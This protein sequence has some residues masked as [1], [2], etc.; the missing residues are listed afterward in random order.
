[1][2]LPIISAP[3]LRSP[4]AA[5]VAVIGADFGPNWT[6]EIIGTLPT[7]AYPSIAYETRV[8]V[9]GGVWPYTYELFNTIPSGMS[10]SSSTGIIT[11]TAPS[12]TSNHTIDIRITDQ[13]GVQDT[14]NYTI[15]VDATNFFF[16]DAS[17]TDDTGT[18]AIGDPWKTLGKANTT[19][20][21][22][23]SILIR[24]GTYSITSAT[25]FSNSTPTIWQAYP[26]DTQ[27]VISVSADEGVRLFYDNLSGNF[28][29]F[30]G[31]EFT[32][33]DDKTFD[34][35][36]GTNLMFYKNFMHDIVEDG[37]NNNP[38]FVSFV[39]IGASFHENFRFMNNVCTSITGTGSESKAA[40]IAFNVHNSLWESN[41][42]TDI[43]AYGLLDKD[44]TFHN[45]YRDN[46]ISNC[47]RTMS[48]KAQ[49]GADGCNIHHNLFID[50]TRNSYG[51]SGTPMTEIYWHHNMMRDTNFEF[52]NNMN[53]ESTISMRCQYNVM[54]ITGSFADSI[55][56]LYRTNATVHDKILDGTVFEA[57]NNII[58]LVDSDHCAGEDEGGAPY[59]TQA[60]WVSGGQDTNSSFETVTLTGIDDTLGLLG[61]DDNF[62]SHGYQLT[63]RTAG[64]L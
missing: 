46:Y 13:L 32:G 20:A 35:D 37:A 29:L 62:G 16:I 61:S 28:G 1:M 21:Q 34:V 3:F 2:L 49:G 42:I 27:P 60:S 19:A 30:Q 58:D 22:G 25:T 4:I 23:D 47:S 56:S 18:G 38:A 31:I 45:T 40:T 12:G 52:F 64:W 6:L 9:I 33:G 53:S 43:P 54:I 5:A 26:G 10:I 55:N 51:E 14:Y 57:D 59:I 15:N 63:G 41:H 50:G 8:A 17:A 36:G 39:D 44:D 7:N 24:A 48:V 11:W